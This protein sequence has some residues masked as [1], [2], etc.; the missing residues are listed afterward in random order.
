MR[1]QF[2]TVFT[3]LKMNF[4]PSF[5]VM[6]FWLTHS[7]S[8]HYFLRKNF[9]KRVKQRWKTGVSPKMF[10]YSKATV[11]P[12]LHSWAFQMCKHTHS[13][14]LP[15][16]RSSKRSPTWHGNH[17]SLHSNENNFSRCRQRKKK[18]CIRYCQYREPHCLTNPQIFVRIKLVQLILQT[19]RSRLLA[20]RHTHSIKYTLA[21]RSQS[22]KNIKQKKNYLSFDINSIENFVIK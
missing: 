4:F 12:E 5:S 14:L 8:K 19:G 3:W 6:L 1:V 16:Q 13:F 9:Q 11:V 22:C 10:P 2:S 15:E 17:T 18:V 20:S 21:R 7:V